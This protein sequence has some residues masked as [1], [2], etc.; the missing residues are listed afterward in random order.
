MMIP[1][2]VNNCHHPADLSIDP[3]AS[4]AW[5]E[6]MEAWKPVSKIP[7]ICRV[8]LLAATQYFKLPTLARRP[9]DGNGTT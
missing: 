9:G 2:I 1:K 5:H 6:G 3:P 4:L 8:S 7:N